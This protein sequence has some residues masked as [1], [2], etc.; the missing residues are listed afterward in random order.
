[1]LLRSDD[2]DIARFGPDS[3]S[4]GNPKQMPWIKVADHAPYFMTEAGEGWTPI[5]HNDAIA[6]DDLNPLFRRRNVDSVRSHLRWLRAHGVNCIR[7]M[8][9][10]CQGKHRFLERPAGTFV[11]SIVQMWDDL[12]RLCEEEQIR[13]L[14]T[15]Y[16]T[17]WMWQH[18]KYH[19]YSVANG[20]CLD[21]PSRLLTCPEARAA[22]KRRLDFAARRW[23]GSGALFAWDLWNEIHPAQAGGSADVFHE[24]I[25][26]ISRF[27][28]EIEVELY[29][30]SH[31]RTVSLFGPELKWRPHLRMEEPIFRHPDLDFASIHIYESGTIDAPRNTVDAAVA[32][33]RI[34]VKS[35]AEMPVERPFLDTEHGPINTYKDGRR[36]LAAEFDDEYFRHMQWA[37]L[38][39]GGAGGGMRWPNRTPHRLTQGMR[40]AQAG[41]AGFVDLIDWPRFRRRSLNANI[42]V[43]APAGMDAAAKRRAARVA[44]FGCGDERQAVVWLLRTDLK[45]RGAT[46]TRDQPLRVTVRVPGLAPGAYRITPWFTREGRAAQPIFAPAGED[47]LDLPAFDLASDMAFAIVRA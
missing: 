35:I 43:T 7:L 3:V 21:H 47:G 15:P 42:R 40:L 13:I 19:P 38:A 23:G 6:W 1:M 37:H 31:P 28:K 11:P 41:L 14:L 32:M 5:G 39:S 16:D 9:E 46:M 8:L 34:V 2:A 30:R 33:G 4:A 12:L 29:G 27:V 18:W 24:F 17:F 10:Y 26:D 20:G 45:A 25:S 36:T 44:A 22:I